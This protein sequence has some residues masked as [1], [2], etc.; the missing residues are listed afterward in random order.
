MGFSEATAT[1]VCTFSKARRSQ[2]S[3]PRVAVIP[4]D[5][6]RMWPISTRVLKLENDDPSIVEPIKLTAN[7]T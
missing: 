6:K 7:A 3:Y 2:K 4:A 1:G 5:L